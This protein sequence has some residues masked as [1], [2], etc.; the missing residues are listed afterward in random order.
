MAITLR[1]TGGD[2]QLMNPLMDLKAELGAMETE[3][4]VD[5]ATLDTR[6][7][8]KGK[9][10][11]NVFS[12]PL[13]SEFEAKTGTQ[14]DTFGTASATSFA[15]LNAGM[16]ATAEDETDGTAGRG[17][18]SARP[19][20][21]APAQEEEQKA[22]SPGELVKKA[23]DYL[24]EP[25]VSRREVSSAEGTDA[26]IFAAMFMFIDIQRLEV[27][28]MMDTVKYNNDMARE[29]EKLKGL[30]QAAVDRLRGA[31]GK[32]PTEKLDPKVI[33]YLWA[34]NVE[35][36]GV[37]VREKY[38]NIQA[39]SDKQWTAGELTQVVTALDIKRTEYTDMNSQNMQ[40]LQM[41]LGLLQ[42]FQQMLTSLIDSWKRVKESIASKL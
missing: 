37:P 38:P 9:G 13:K 3:E 34:N 22:I 14:Y 36:E 42:V 30:V 11:L 2:V 26:L 32:N 6:K 4:F 23:E 33:A 31:D 28:K 35:I 16:A 5:M 24:A 17:S 21:V 7:Q 40:K 20:F 39:L 27:A 15:A 1:D 10:R 18:I 19:V 25:L 8:G 41:A 29:L 12:K